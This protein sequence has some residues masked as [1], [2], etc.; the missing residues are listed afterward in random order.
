MNCRDI[1]AFLKVVNIFCGLDSFL[2]LLSKFL[3][4][5]CISGCQKLMLK[6]V[7]Q[8][9]FSWQGF[10]WNLEHIDFCVSIFLFFL[11]RV[12]I[13]HLLW[14]QYVWL[15]LCTQVWQHFDKSIRKKLLH[16]VVLHIWVWLFLLCLQWMKLELLGPFLPCRHTELEV[17]LCFS[18]LDIF[19]TVLIQKRWNILE[20]V[21]Q[22]CL[23][24]ASTSSFSHCVIWHSLW[25]LIL[26][27]SFFLCVEFSKEMDFPWEFL[28]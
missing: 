7:Q 12:P 9:V 26:L 6:E 4:C 11:T 2:H 5:L 22:Q 20:D 28:F 16:I 1:W 13:L 15:E 10:C 14:E 21:Q 24:L 19:M 25:H 18:V 3:L 17:Q 23:C 8:E 27:E